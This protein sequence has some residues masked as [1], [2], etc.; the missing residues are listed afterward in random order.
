MTIVAEL[1]SPSVLPLATD[2]VA[3]S[4]AAALETCVTAA[5]VVASAPIAA[6][7][8]TDSIITRGIRG[9]WVEEVVAI[10]LLQRALSPRCA[11]AKLLALLGGGGVMGDGGLR[12][13]PRLEGV[14]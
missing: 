8:A 4:V 5:A 14:A 10:A 12:Q 1:S 2:W 3:V 9:A 6:V 7:A 13:Q 11:I